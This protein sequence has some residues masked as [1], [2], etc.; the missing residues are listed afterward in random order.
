M[1]VLNYKSYN[2]LIWEFYLICIYLM[3]PL[4]VADVGRKAK[5][6]RL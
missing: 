4:N 6:G 5:T 1:S 3:D 2:F